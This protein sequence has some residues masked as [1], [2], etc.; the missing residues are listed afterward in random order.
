MTTRRKS[1]CFSP[2]EKKYSVASLLI[3][4]LHAPARI[5]ARAAFIIFYEFPFRDSTPHAPG[6]VS[7]SVQVRA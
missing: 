3:A 7:G 1:R 4:I 5:L 6:V 2:E